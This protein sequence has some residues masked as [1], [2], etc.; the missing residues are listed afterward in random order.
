MHTIVPSLYQHQHRSA[1][2]RSLCFC[3]AAMVTAVVEL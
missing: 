2:A 1:M 3:L